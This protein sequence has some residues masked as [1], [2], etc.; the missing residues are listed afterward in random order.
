MR[1][2]NLR[3]TMYENIGIGYDDIFIDSESY[4]RI[5]HEVLNSMTSSKV[6]GDD[7]ECDITIC[8]IPVTLKFYPDIIVEDAGDHKEI[9]RKIRM[10]MDECIPKL[11]CNDLLLEYEIIDSKEVDE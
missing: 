1:E 5:E 4:A 3:L 10:W 6:I 8:R 7:V 11:R 2:L 9:E